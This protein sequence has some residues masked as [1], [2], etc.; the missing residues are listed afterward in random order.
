MPSAVF[1]T[2]FFE[3][4][5]HPV[6]HDRFEFRNPLHESITRTEMMLS[7]YKETGGTFVTNQVERA[8]LAALRVKDHLGTV[9]R[10]YVAFMGPRT[11]GLNEPFDWEHDLDKAL[12]LEGALDYEG[13]DTGKSTNHDLYFHDGTVVWLP[14]AANNAWAHRQEMYGMLMDVVIH[15]RAIRDDL[16]NIYLRISGPS[17]NAQEEQRDLRFD[18]CGG[19]NKRKREVDSFVKPNGAEFARLPRRAPREA[20]RRAHTPVWR[21][22]TLRHS[23]RWAPR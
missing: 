18:L 22:R 19:E 11:N 1:S 6:F 17:M 13:L 14:T 15:L 7:D 2:R 23:S 9:A 12:L 16:D 8:F 21:G 3:K 20:C 10:R 4:L 5:N